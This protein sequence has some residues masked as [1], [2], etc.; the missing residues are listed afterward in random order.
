MD[1]SLPGS[2]VH[3][4]LQARTLEWVFSS[5]GDLLTQ[6]LNTNLSHCRQI[7]YRLSHQGRSQYIP[8]DDLK[9]ISSQYIF[10]M[11]DAAENDDETMH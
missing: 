5:P 9:K 3:G 2:S 1:C 8:K 4:T 7:L 10:T 11:V 6:G